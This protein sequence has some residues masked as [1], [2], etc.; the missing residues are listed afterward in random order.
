MSSFYIYYLS[1]R[2][3]KRGEWELWLMKVSVAIFK[4]D[5]VVL[6]GAGFGLIWVWVSAERHFVGRG[7][8]TRPSVSFVIISIYFLYFPAMNDKLVHGV[9]FFYWSLYLDWIGFLARERITYIFYEFAFHP[10][11]FWRWLY[12]DIVGPCLI[13]TGAAITPHYLHE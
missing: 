9:D 3:L 10:L 11:P 6:K 13:R 4:L 12:L 5:G 8:A 1:S 2:I 7:S